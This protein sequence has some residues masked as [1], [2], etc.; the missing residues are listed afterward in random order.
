M[1]YG[2]KEK[3][4]IPT[5]LSNKPTLLK[6]INTNNKKNELGRLIVSGWIQLVYQIHFFLI[7]SKFFRTIRRIQ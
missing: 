2:D 5:I 4:T 1:L 3:H 6:N 7:A